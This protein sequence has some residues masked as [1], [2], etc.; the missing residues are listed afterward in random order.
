MAAPVVAG[1]A[2][3]AFQAHPEWTNDQVKWLLQNTSTALNVSAGQGA[4]EVNADALVRYSGTPGY[5]NQGLTIS[6]NLVTTNGAVAYNSASWSTASW[7][8]ASWSTAS[9]STA[10]LSTAKFVAL[11]EKSV[12]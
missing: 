11:S 1:V 8:A 3:L 10:N 12:K 2:A 6:D 5:A 4:G 9:W 7:S